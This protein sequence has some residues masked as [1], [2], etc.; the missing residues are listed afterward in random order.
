MAGDTDPAV[1][2]ETSRARAGLA[3]LILFQSEIH[4]H[5]MV[6]STF[7][8]ALPCSIK[9][10]RKHSHRQTRRCVPMVIP[11][12]IKLQS[13]LPITCKDVWMPRLCGYSVSGSSSEFPRDP[14]VVLTSCF[15]SVHLLLSSLCF[16]CSTLP[17]PSHSS[18][19][20]LAS[21]SWSI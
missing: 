20:S 11:N 3:L 2:T 9:L 21:G 6:L 1:R 19:S 15:G 10:L 16:P 5:E 18:T 8:V 14:S 13:K 17:A 7:R 4:V 12:P